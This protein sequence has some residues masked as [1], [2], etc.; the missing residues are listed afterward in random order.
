MNFGK[1]LELC[2]KKRDISLNSV[3]NLLGLNRGDLYHVID[4]KR[5]LKP[6]IF[7]RL[8]NEIGFSEDEE[9]KLADFYFSDFYG[10]KEFEKIKY[11][12]KRLNGFDAELKVRE[13]HIAD[14]EKKF[15]LESEDDIFSAV[16]YL[17][18]NSKGQS[19]ITNYSYESK[20]LDNL[21]YS[22]CRKKE[23]K[24]F[25]HI[26]PFGTGG[27]D[28]YNL[29]L[30]FSSIKFLYYKQFPIYYYSDNNK[31]AY[32][33]YPFYCLS[34]DY[35]VLFSENSGIFIEDKKAV[36]ALV[37]RA[38]SFADKCHQL[39]E[40]MPNI[41]EVKDIYVASVL[42]G[43][44]I[45]EIC[46]IPCMMCYTDLDFFYSISKP[47]I[48]NRD[49]LAHMAYEHYSNINK[50]VT[51]NQYITVEGLDELF[52]NRECLEMPSEYAN[53]IPKETLKKIFEKMYDAVKEGKMHILNPKKLHIP[54]DLQI[55]INAGGGLI[56]GYV[57]EEGKPTQKPFWII[58]NDKSLI[59]NL[60]YFFDYLERGNFFFGKD[61]ALAYISNRI[62][63]L[64]F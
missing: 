12:C 5:K 41:F 52:K 15:S 1:Y 56:Y 24:D 27:N 30:L 45:Y 31:E 40:E 49:F 59:D 29:N 44:E 22:L 51:Y 50:T 33:P 26:I 7:I 58:I 43:T 4:S 64:A 63:S 60:K 13:D 11:I 18:E 62:V 61:T 9:E 28:V 25:K 21:F 32:E 3:A 16:L 55:E 6:E 23:L 35:A 39:G 42:D 47:E 48:P 36:A 53:L 17:C 2:L 34:D 38:K 46:P 54:I 57:F 37:K 14:F 19:V 8:I 10:S 20:R